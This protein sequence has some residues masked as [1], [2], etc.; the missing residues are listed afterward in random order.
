ML[1][2]K[3][4][5]A[6]EVCT[7]PVA[8]VLGRL[9]LTPNAI[10]VIGT[11]G[12]A[13]SAAVLY[14]LQHYLLGTL[15]VTFFVLFDMLDGT[16]A[17]LRG[18]TSRWGAFLDSTLDRIADG[19]VFGSLAAAAFLSGRAAAGGL[20]LSA[21]VFA[22]TVSYTRA[23]GEAVGG[24]GSGGLMERTERLIVVLVAAGCVGLGAPY[25]V[26]T[27]ALALVAAGALVTVFQRMRSVFLS[28]KSEDTV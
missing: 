12:T 23:R 5:G 4:R 24:D 10:T 27:S 11:V 15:A 9:G 13:V 6:V 22:F 28:V 17:R 25:S 7:R 1:T 16:L 8:A 20:A 3:L 19:A 26:L 2:S 18:T 21:L 14:P